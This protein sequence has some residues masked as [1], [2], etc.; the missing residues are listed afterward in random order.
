MMMITTFS[1]AF[2]YPLKLLFIKGHM[3]A[4]KAQTGGGWEQFTFR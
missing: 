2:R 3:S 4:S 1:L